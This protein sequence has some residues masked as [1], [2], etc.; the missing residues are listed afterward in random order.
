[1]KSKRKKLQQFIKESMDRIVAFAALLIFFPV[2]TIVAILIYLQMGFPIL[3]VQPRCGR[4]SQIFNFYKFRT[5]TN[6][7]DQE[8]NLLPDEQRSTPLGQFLRR[9]SLD[10]LPQLWNVFKGDMSLVGPRP[11]V[12]RYLPRYTAE[13][14]RRHEVKPGITGWAQ[15]NGRN[16]IS[17][18]K[19]FNLD[20]WY[21][22]HW[23]LWL[24]L[25]ILILTAWI[26]MRKEGTSQQEEFRGSSGGSV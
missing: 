22:E 10:E 18:E 8:G 3:F 26:V 5:L 17:W 15:I 11:L 16:G 7:R 19:K 14:A 23:N 20:V 6:D 21:V 25:K 9:S 24:D 1:M 13:Q 2:L 12:V 4:N